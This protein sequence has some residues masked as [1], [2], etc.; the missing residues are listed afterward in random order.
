MVKCRKIVNYCI[1]ILV[2]AHP[3]SKIEKKSSGRGLYLKDDA[4]IRICD[5][6]NDNSVLVRVAACSTLGLFSFVNAGLLSQ[7]LSKRKLTVL[8][9]HFR[10]VDHANDVEA[11]DFN[12]LSQAES[13]SSILDAGACGAFVHGYYRFALFLRSSRLEDEFLEVRKATVRAICQLSSSSLEFAQKSLDYLFDMFND[14]QEEIRMD[15]IRGLEKIFREFE[16][17]EPNGLQLELSQLQTAILITQ[18]SSPQCRQAAYRV[19]SLLPLNTAEG[20]F[21]IV[22]ALIGNL[23]R[24]PGDQN[25]IRCGIAKLGAKN[26]LL[27]G[28]FH[29]V[30]SFTETL[31]P[32]L[33]KIEKYY[34]PREISIENERGIII[35][36]HTADV[37]Y[38]LMVFA[39]AIATPSL[40][41]NI[42]PY[43]ESMRVYFLNKFPLLLKVKS[44]PER[45]PS[46]DASLSYLHL[47]VREINRRLDLS[48]CHVNSHFLVTTTEYILPNPKISETCRLCWIKRT[49]WPRHLLFLIFCYFLNE[50]QL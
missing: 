22:D 28:L 41:R 27:V 17:Q 15:T 13:T 18:D 35:F 47:F 12:M 8:N 48:A 32:E 7:T 37:S 39:S 19:L 2:S 3:R 34:T 30:T 45:S 9:R 40:F 29:N 33:F 44:C 21:C 36:S 31:I 1:R 5:L 49:M 16:N 38:L 50:S 6:M 24:Y 26:A 43:L 10:S 4:F 23:S 42:P 14:S 11:G 46:A 25:S 20:L